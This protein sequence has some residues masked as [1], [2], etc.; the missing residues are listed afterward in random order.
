M[1]LFMLLVASVSIPLWAIFI[2]G[3]YY[4][5]QEGNTGGGLFALTMGSTMAVTVTYLLWVNY[6]HFTFRKFPLM[7]LDNDGLHFFAT[8]RVFVPWSEVVNARIQVVKGITTIRIEPKFPKKYRGRFQAWAAPEFMIATFALKGSAE[9][10][11]K[12]IQGHRKYIGA[13]PR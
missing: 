6:K 5:I 11:L 9:D 10:L 12:A 3:G 4:S 8:K 13:A 7:V 2:I 1:A